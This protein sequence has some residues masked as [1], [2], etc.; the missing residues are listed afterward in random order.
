HRQRA[1]DDAE[2]LGLVR[3]E[4]GGGEGAVRGDERLEAE[5]VAARLAGGLVEDE[6]LPCDRILDGL[7]CDDHGLLSLLVALSMTRRACGPGGVDRDGA[8]PRQNPCLWARN[9]SVEPFV[10]P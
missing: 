8:T 4:V 9:G 6:P 1:G 3:V 7:P 5:V 10:R 2:R